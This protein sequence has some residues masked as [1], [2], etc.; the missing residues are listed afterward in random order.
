MFNINEVNI[1]YGADTTGIT[2]GPSGTNVT[3]NFSGLQAITPKDSSASKY[4]YPNSTP[5]GTDFPGADIAT[6]SYSGNSYLEKALHSML[7]V[8]FAHRALDAISHELLRWRLN[9]HRSLLD[10]IEGNS[11]QTPEEALVIHLRMGYN[12]P[13]RFSSL[14]IGT[15]AAGFDSSVA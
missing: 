4:V 15:G 7:P 11:R 9:H 6:Q 2:P 13:E 1:Q 5:Y 10:V 12:N 8:L 3:W 14:A